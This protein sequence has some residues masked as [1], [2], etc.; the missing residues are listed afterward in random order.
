[1]ELTSKTTGSKI[2]EYLRFYKENTRSSFGNLDF[3]PTDEHR[4]LFTVLLVLIYFKPI[5]IPIKFS[6]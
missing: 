4:H 1:M 6:D 3:T 5:Y 2:N